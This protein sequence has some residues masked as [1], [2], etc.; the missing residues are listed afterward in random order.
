MKVQPPAGP[1]PGTKP[2]ELGPAAKTKDAA[3]PSF[4]QKAA[5]VAQVGA[6]QAAEA[7]PNAAAPRPAS[8]AGASMADHIDAIAREM[9]AGR[10][11]T[12][13][14]AVGAIVERVLDAKFGGRLPAE[15][16]GQMKAA[17]AAQ[18]VGDPGLSER[19]DALLRKAQA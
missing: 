8:V 1:P 16:F 3:G 18:I 9:R 12:R 2:D 14:Q 11:E 10:I 4:A 5:D 13:E 6:V 7:T 19:I 15:S 17:V